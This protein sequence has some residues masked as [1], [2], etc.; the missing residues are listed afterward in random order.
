MKNKRIQRNLILQK[1]HQRNAPWRLDGGL[2]IP[3]EY[4][5][6]TRRALTWSDDV[7]F[8][9]NR[10]QVLVW[11]QHPRCTYANKI[12]ELAWLEAGDPPHES[13]FF[14]IAETHWEKI[15]R[16]RKKIKYQTTKPIVAELRDFYA[17]L[18]AIENRMATDG[19]DFVIRPAM[20]I[21]IYPNL[22]GVDL[23]A[24]IDV[25][26]EKE[27]GDLATLAKQLLKRE[28]SLEQRFPDYTYGRDD[29]LAEAGLRKADKQ[30]SASGD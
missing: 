3:H 17:R 24:P 19:I 27:V 25:R 28:T 15:G 16:S 12:S 13:D 10:R 2:F 6:S 20:R 11:M 18:D 23:Y 9:L 22:L 8:V 14:E 21:Q 29:W 30:I 7:G 4:T 26:D 5:E 1:Q